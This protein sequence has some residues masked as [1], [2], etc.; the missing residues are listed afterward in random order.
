MST[1][2]TPPA[3]ETAQFAPNGRSRT[4]WSGRA[5]PDL[6]EREVLIAIREVLAPWQRHPVVVDLIRSD[7]GHSGSDVV[8]AAPLQLG[9]HVGVRVDEQAP[10]VGRLARVDR[11]APCH[12][13]SPSGLRAGRQ[14]R[15]SALEL[16]WVDASLAQHVRKAHVRPLGSQRP[17]TERMAGSPPPFPDAA[18][19]AITAV[20]ARPATANL[21]FD[22]SS[23]AR[24]AL[25]RRPGLPASKIP[26]KAIFLGKET[27]YPV[28][29]V[30]PFELV[31]PHRA[32]PAIVG[33]RYRLEA[34]RL[35]SARLSSRVSANCAVPESTRHAPPPR[36]PKGNN[37]HR[38]NP[39]ALDRDLER[40]RLRNSSPHQ[41][42][43]PLQRPALAA[44]SLETVQ[45][46]ER[47]SARH[48]RRDQRHRHAMPVVPQRLADCC[49]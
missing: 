14:A 31:P 10:L 36:Q 37:E 8:V 45:G 18:P 23:T 6:R 1:P 16:S 2:A 24:A 35:S 22:H 44:S 5:R 12:G 15:R 38:L 42:G 40:S 46:P 27:H 28:A 26:R 7:P 11:Q 49:C 48:S 34:E 17:P 47:L 43:L 41:P 33:C 21:R 32:R 30:E 39:S 13:G 3:C 20:D 9:Q 29:P 4:A 25:R 19:T